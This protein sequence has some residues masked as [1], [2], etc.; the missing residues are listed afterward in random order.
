M[1]IRQHNLLNKACS[2]MLLK[3]A[4]SSWPALISLKIWKET[5]W[6][7]MQKK[8]T[9]RGKQNTMK[10]PISTKCTRLWWRIRKSLK[11]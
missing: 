10:T 5:R 9:L 11:S 6:T 8:R 7:T 2:N 4:L 3:R 1:E